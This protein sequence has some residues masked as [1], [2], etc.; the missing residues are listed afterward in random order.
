MKTKLI[1]ALVIFVI[2]AAGVLA[3]V[4]RKQA[5]PE[6]QTQ[7]M[8]ETAKTLPIDT[9]HMSGT[10]TAVTPTKISFDATLVKDGQNTTVHSSAIIDSNTKIMSSVGGSIVSSNISNIKAGS[11]LDFST[12]TYP[13]D[14][15]EI[16]PYQ[17]M[18][19]K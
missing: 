5:K 3:Y 18:I 1:F 16:K 7:S 8:L 12:K 9:F 19:V 13:Y 10:V 2:I 4:R 6:Q 11:V 15:A 17:V 14:Q